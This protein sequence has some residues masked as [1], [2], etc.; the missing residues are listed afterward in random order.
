MSTQYR[1]HK[2]TSNFLDK[3]VV[4]KNAPHHINTRRKAIDYYLSCNVNFWEAKPEGNS[5]AKYFAA[6]VGSSSFI[7]LSKSEYLYAMSKKNYKNNMLA[8][9]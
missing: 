5:T 9:A 1:E 8:S 2:N 3:E 7:R 6:P 4:F